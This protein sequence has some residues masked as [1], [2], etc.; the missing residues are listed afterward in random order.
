MKWWSASELQDQV[1]AVGRIFV[2]YGIASAAVSVGVLVAF[3]GLRGLLAFDAEARNNDLTTIPFE[4][5][6]AAFYVG[7]SL[8]LAG[9][10]VV[11]GRG[12]LR[13]QLWAH[14]G[15]ILA[16]AATILLFPF[17]TAVGVHALWVMLLP[18]TE[19]L[20][21]NP[22]AVFRRP[23]SKKSGPARWP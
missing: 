20:F 13:W 1:R 6:V 7:F 10:L 2:G 19:P 9:P 15:G 5:L 8:L 3:G 4:R 21:L 17:G 11:V 18:E 23:E 12:I 14:T 16:A 22:P